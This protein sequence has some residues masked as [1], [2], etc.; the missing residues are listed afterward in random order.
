MQ[1]RKTLAGR[2]LAFS[3]IANS[4]LLIVLGGVLTMLS[5]N[6][7]VDEVAGSSEKMLIQ[8]NRVLDTYLT[9]VRS[10]IVRLTSMQGIISCM[11][12]QDISFAESLP[13]EREMDE[14]LSGIDL[15]S[16]IKD[17]LILGNNGYA[18]NL[19]RRQNLRS[20]YDFTATQWY[21]QAITVEDGRYIQML[22]L[23]DQS[24][25]TEKYEPVASKEKTISLSMAV[26]SHSYKI[27]GA[28]V[29]NLDLRSLSQMFNDG[30]YEQSG[31]IALIDP[32]GIIC[33][34][35]DGERTGER[36]SLCEEDFARMNQTENGH[37]IAQMDGEPYLVCHDTSDF[38]GWKLVYYVPQRAIQNHASP[39]RMILLPSLLVG[40]ALNIVV[41]LSYSRSVQRPVAGLI[42]SLSQVDTDN[43]GPIPVRTEYAELEQ[44]SLKF[45]ELLEQIDQLIKKDYRTQLELSRFELAALQSQINPH[46]LFNTLQLLQTEIIYGNVEK[47]N[48]III[49]L[50]Q[51]MRY[52]MAG[53]ESVVPVS[54]E[55]EYLKKYLMLF[56]SKYEGR[57]STHFDV[58]PEAGELTMPKLLMQ[59]VVENSIRHALDVNPGKCTISILVQLVGEDLII[60]IRDDGQGMDEEKLKQIRAGLERRVD[61]MDARIGLAN[62]HQRVMTLYGPGYGL[63]I[64]S[65]AG[66]TTVTIRLPGTPPE[67]GGE[68]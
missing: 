4:V 62:I 17:V 56:T 33:A 40:I 26:F 25:Y 28:I 49:S 7:L 54:R 47:S 31:R 43:L 12:T 29:C 36:I 64:D 46:F 30:N 22:S 3:L 32:E 5:G 13:Y 9:D 48:Q 21:R 51:L 55:I 41:A 15:F 67:R 34:Q 45:N 50:S 53:G 39:L 35:S 23:H 61:W 63:T 18:Y 10:R 52:Y 42:D 14:V 20:G 38:S 8:S 24:Y 68:K 16:P 60:R 1:F 37:F 66:G 65:G 59:P 44:I 2:F 58:K 11:S 19:N 57:L 27:V 6:V